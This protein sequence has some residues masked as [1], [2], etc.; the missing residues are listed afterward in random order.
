MK[1][2]EK[3]L[4]VPFN[5]KDKSGY[6][7]DMG[8]YDWESLNTDN[9]FGICVPDESYHEKEVWFEHLSHQVINFQ[10]KPEGVYGD[11]R[12]LD[13]KEGKNLQAMIDEGIEIVFRIGGVVGD[14]DLKRMHIGLLEL[15]S[16][17][18]ILKEHDQYDEIIYRNYKLNKLMNE[19]QGG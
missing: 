12:I 16:V 10:I 8:S 18:A 19:I 4:L 5:V 1:Y 3:E 7:Y 17:H 14:V 9:I 15:E 13:T 6:Y 11:I 2:L